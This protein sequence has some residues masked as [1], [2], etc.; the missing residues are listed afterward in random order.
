MQP[1]TISGEVKRRLIQRCGHSYD[2]VS[3]RESK[4]EYSSS[5]GWAGLDLAEDP[6]SDLGTLGAVAIIIGIDEAGYGPLLGPLCVAA[7]TFRADPAPPSPS[8]A[9][10][11]SV[12]TL[13]GE[14]DLWSRLESAVCRKPRDPRGRVAIA[15]SKKLKRPNDAS[16]HPLEH[17][18]RGVL[19]CLA[20]VDGSAVRPAD[21]LA[22]L[23]AV[24]ARPCAAPPWE[25]AAVPLPLANDPALI[26]IAAAMLARTMERAGVHLL[27]LRVA[28]LDA[29]DFNGAL[30][31]TRSK[32]SVNTS[33]AFEHLLDAARRFP[34]ERIV[35]AFDRHGGRMHYREELA[36][37]FPDAR[38]R[39]LEETETRSSYE[40]VDGDRR[41]H[42]SWEVESESKHL[43]VALAS[44]TAKLVRELWMARLN[45]YFAQFLPE[46]KPTAGYVE[47]GRRWLAEVTPHLPRIGV[48]RERLVRQA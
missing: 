12:P 31:R 38:I 15:D 30:A 37:T 26:G 5:I 17:L 34:R 48:D 27:R 35:A 10:S 23:D 22:L 39:V 46:L 7:A 24:G 47:D 13:P 11:V 14:I 4:A 36:F 3:L 45:R 42:A 2:R 1:A 44:M 18:E 28:A 9:A 41:I 8:S 19:A 33:V 32:A 43:P 21:D 40:L 29:P 6:E 25:G 20:T 16:G